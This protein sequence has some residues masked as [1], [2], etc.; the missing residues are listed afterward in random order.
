MKLL[1]P[2]SIL[3]FAAIVIISA[4]ACNS[5]NSGT[6]TEIATIQKGNIGISI[7]A[8]GSLVTS[9]E[10][11]LTFYS[12]GTVESV[13]VEVGDMVAEGDVLAQLETADLESSLAQA[14]INVKQ[15]RIDLEDAQEP[16]TN[17]SGTQIVSAPDPL[18][19]EMK[20]LSLKNAKANLAEAEKKL[21]QATITAPFKGLVTEVNAVEGDQVSATT[22]I[23]RLIDPENFETTVYVNETEIYS[24]KEGTEATI[25]ISALPDN[26]YT[27]S[28][29]GISET[30]TISSNVVNYQVTVKLDPVSAETGLQASSGTNNAANGQQSQSPSS[31]NGKS[32]PSGPQDVAVTPTADATSTSADAS[33]DQTHLKEGLTVTVSIIIDSKDD[34]LLVPN[35]AISSSGGKY[36]TQVVTS[37]EGVYER[38]NIQVGITDGTNTEVT[39]GLSENEQVA[40][41]STSSSSST[42]SKNSQNS[43]QQVNMM[44]NTGGGGQSGGGGGPPPQ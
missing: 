28:V 18:K 11:N 22:T 34:I 4:L 42:S 3:P 23:I 7:L 19:I 41:V 33:S 35:K 24:V 39:S 26:I 8:S 27:A 13:I 43:T 44:L 14:E 40:V 32:A 12:S 9:N 5:G 1:K 38:R 10:A 37:T 20:E 16:T 29:D 31:F 2:A 25:T 15:A 6:T 36:Y 21:Q 30:A 17:S